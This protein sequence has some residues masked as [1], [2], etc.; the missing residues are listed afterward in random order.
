MI[1]LADALKALD[2]VDL[3]VDGGTDIGTLRIFLSQPRLTSDEASDIKSLLFY[4][5]LEHAE[6]EAYKK[7]AEIAGED[8]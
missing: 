8:E 7:L 2:Q 4:H 1:K 6:P 5:S 3:E